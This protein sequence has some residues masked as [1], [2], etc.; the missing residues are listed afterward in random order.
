ME[1]HNFPNK[2]REVYI[3]QYL[4]KILIMISNYR[5]NSLTNIILEKNYRPNVRLPFN[6]RVKLLGLSL[7]PKLRWH[8][9]EL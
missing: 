3:V 9:N 8:I 5:L 2:W 1:K 6:R 7:Y 4:S